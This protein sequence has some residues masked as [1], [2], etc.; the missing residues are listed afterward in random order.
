[1]R[2]PREPGEW[3]H[4]IASRQRNV[5]FPDTARN[6]AQFWRNV[7]SRPWNIRA[8]IGIFLF[9]LLGFGFLV[10][11]L[12]A[13]AQEGVLWKLVLGIVLLFGPVF[14][15]IAWATRR[16]LRDIEETRRVKWPKR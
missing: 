14:A 1:M 12:F 9:G 7:G 16:N 11:L 8:A 3:R 15:V 5:V 2:K 6:E 10:R 13:S 4:D